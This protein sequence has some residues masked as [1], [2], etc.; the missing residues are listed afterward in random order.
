MRRYRVTRIKNSC[1]IKALKSIFQADKHYAARDHSPEFTT[2]YPTDKSN[3]VKCSLY[4]Y[5]REV[6]LY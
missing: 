6:S 1:M 2:E 5:G 4:H 3:S